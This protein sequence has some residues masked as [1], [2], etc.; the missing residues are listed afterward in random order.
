MSFG[1]ILVVDDE[2][3]VRKS[4]RMTL[5]KAGYEVV[6]AADGEEAINEMRTGDNPIAVDAILCDIRMPK[7]NGIEAMVWFQSQFPSVPIVVMTGHPDVSG[8]TSLMKQGAVDYLVKPVDPVHL[9]A[10]I[11]KVAKDR[12]YKERYGA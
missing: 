4:V 3:D 10:V 2:P 7:M 9:T 12:V 11:N 8:V 5:T 6:E 1:R